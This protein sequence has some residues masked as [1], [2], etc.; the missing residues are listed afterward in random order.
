MARGV[1]NVPDRQPHNALRNHRL[2][3]PLTSASGRVGP[4]GDYLFLPLSQVAETLAGR[5]ISMIGASTWNAW[6]DVGEDENDKPNGR[7]HCGVKEERDKR[8]TS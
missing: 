3:L 8:K 1:E 2:P 7:G 4:A 6:K 5:T